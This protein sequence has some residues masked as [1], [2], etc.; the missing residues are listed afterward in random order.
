MS[1]L[2]FPTRVGVWLREC[3]GPVV[4]CDTQERADRFLEEALELAQANGYDLGRVAAL[5]AYVNARPAGVPYQEVGGV[6]VTL[7]AYCWATG[8]P[9]HAAADAELERIQRP[10]IME[11]IRLKQ[12]AKAREIPFSPLP[13]KTDDDAPPLPEGYA[14]TEFMPGI[15]EWNYRADDDD[16]GGSDGVY[17]ASEAAA[18]VGA[19]RAHCSALEDE[20]EEFNA[21]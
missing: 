13:V 2:D 20:L 15:W 18:V 11:K 9:M 21:E 12:A 16:E 1:A 17:Y 3:F 4:A 7:A 14:V 8:V 10:E 5:V 19:W 6:M